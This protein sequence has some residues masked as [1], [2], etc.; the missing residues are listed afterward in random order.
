MSK[1]HKLACLLICIA[2]LPLCLSSQQ[3]DRTNRVF[4]NIDENQKPYFTFELSKDQTLYS[5]CRFFNVALE[6]AMQRNGIVDPQDIPLGRT[7]DLPLNMYNYSNTPFE[8]TKY[9]TLV[10]RV[11]KQETLYRIAKVYFK[12]DVKDFIRM[13]EL[14]GFSLDIGQELVVGY[15][16]AYHPREYEMDAPQDNPALHNRQEQ[17]NAVNNGLTYVG[18]VSDE[19][20]NVPVSPQV[21]NEI[22]DL[23]EN[24]DSTTTQAT[25]DT[26]VKELITDSEIDSIVKEEI[27]D[28]PNTKTI[29]RKG[30]AYWD[31]R[32]TDYENMMVL[33]KHA[34]VNTI[35]KL[36]NPV[37]GQEVFARVVGRIP[38]N[39]FKKDIEVVIS[40]AVAQKI[41][42]LDS[43]CQLS[44]TYQQ[45]I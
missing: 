15:F 8:N 33:H 27:L 12:Q 37:N 44:M 4:I 9:I 42:V 7:I 28:V 22:R 18:V 2:G 17:I 5:S 45:K 35:I 1:I 41:G 34:V 11:K 3:T 38:A 26:I 30:I 24:I 29:T 40:P 6:D 43:R 20:E 13:N 19:K 23:K 32:G 36:K 39:A 31:K 14:S 21:E 25:K 10:Y 16:A